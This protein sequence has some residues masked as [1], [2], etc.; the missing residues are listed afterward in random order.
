MSSE[1]NKPQRFQIFRAKDAPSLVEANCMTP[2]P[3]TE[4]QMAG[5]GKLIEAGLFEGDE[6]K[7]LCNIPGFSL[8]NVWFKPGYP[9]PL[10]RHDSDCLYYIVAGNVE[11]GTESLGPRDTFFVPANTPYTYKTG[12]EGVEL[13]EFRHTTHFSFGVLAKTEAFWTRAAEQTAKH[14]ESWKTA[15]RPKVNEE[16]VAKQPVE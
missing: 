8:T 14:R 9:L 15:T 5:F 4:V 12:P 1:E 13:L 16:A 7:V 10:H 6:V 11:L 3:F 2:E